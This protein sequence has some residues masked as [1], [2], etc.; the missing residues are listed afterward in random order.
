MKILFITFGDVSSC[1]WDIRSASVIRVLADAGHQVA[2]I[3]SSS[4]LADHPNIKNL[5]DGEKTLSRWQL[6]FAVIKATGS[7]GFDMVHAVDDA[8][9]F[10]GKLCAIRKLRFVYDARRCFSGSATKGPFLHRKWFSAYDKKLEK[11]MLGQA[12]RVVAGCSA[13]RDDLQLICSTAD[14]MLVEDI[15]LQ[16]SV[17]SDK[18]NRAALL[19]KFESPHATAVLTC[20][21]MPGKQQE[22]RMILMAARKVID[23][24]PGAV[25]FFHGTDMADAE[26]MA[27]NLDILNRCAF[28]SEKKADRFL[29][30]LKE[31]DA[32]L[33]FPPSG[34][35][36]VQREIYTLM[37]ASVPI[38][39]VESASHKDLLSD[40][41]SIS[42]L[43]SSESMAEGM[44]QAIKEPLFSINLASEGK[45][46]IAERYSLPS[47]KHKIRMLY[48]EVMTRE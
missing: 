27:A 20:S 6:K 41:N 23:S 18:W 39:A 31:A 34:T 2:V 9:I 22:V 13:L 46:M 48:I 8:V 5:S 29:S 36:Y 28:M 11:K 1:G 33:F 43:S 32:S 38:V 4:D 15:P 14:I 30:A 42:V 21:S 3:A 45:K 17:R 10:V 16:S 19:E 12:E 24:I 40:Q 26:A 44:I 37:N 7:P 47:F 25:F 35:R